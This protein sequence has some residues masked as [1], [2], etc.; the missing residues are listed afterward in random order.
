MLSGSLSKIIC[1]VY[2][3]YTSYL[4]GFL[5]LDN[6]LLYLHLIKDQFWWLQSYS[7]Q[8]G[9]YFVL[10]ASFD[11]IDASMYDGLV[12]PGGRA[13]EY[14]AVNESVLKLVKQ[15]SDSNKPIAS[16]CHGQLILAAAG[17]LKEKTCTAFPTVKPVIVAAGGVWKDPESM[18]ACIVDGNLIT[19][20]A[21][22]A[23]PEFISLFV[24]ALGAK[25]TGSG[26]HILF[27][28]GVGVNR[29]KFILFVMTRGF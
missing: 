2:R 29:T 11:D 20:E 21:W 8:R 26:K 1:F 19:G 10:T 12:V 16:I 15:F 6:Y 7:E 17:V 9:H 4:I 28:C 25:V 3:Y 27:L 23:H 22:P 24:K 18:L 14:L 13:P 5:C